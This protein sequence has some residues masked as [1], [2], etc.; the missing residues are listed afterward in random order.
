MIFSYSSACTQEREER[1]RVRQNGTR[2]GIDDDDAVVVVVVVKRYQSCFWLQLF[3]AAIEWVVKRDKLNL[4]KWATRRA[5]VN[6]NTKWVYGSS[7]PLDL[8]CER[9]QHG[10]ET[11]VLSFIFVRFNLKCNLSLCVHEFYLQYDCSYI[12][13]I[14]NKCVHIH[15]Y[16]K[17]HATNINIKLYFSVNV[18]WYVSLTIYMVYNSETWMICALEMQKIKMNYYG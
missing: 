5:H 18:D 8:L 3:V 1:Q 9:I 16:W 6:A 13:C 11:C 15:V 14:Y 10:N 17:A 4:L 2:H 7:A 12:M